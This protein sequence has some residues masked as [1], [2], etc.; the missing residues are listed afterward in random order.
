MRRA[1]LTLV[2]ATLSTSALAD[3]FAIDGQ[4]IDRCLAIN[5]QTPMVCVGRE[6]DVCVERNNGGPNM[7]ISVCMENEGIYWDERLNDTYDRVLAAASDREAL[8]LGYDPEQLTDAL[9]DMQ[10]A[11]IVY[12]DATC[13]HAL[14]LAIPFNSAI[15]PAIHDCLMRET[16]RQVFQLQDIE[17]RYRQ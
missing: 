10:R 2:F 13:D 15:G 4:Q 8:D 11:W 9:R 12:R 17:L 6:A 16:A 1:A 3:R 7:V 14:A 5:A